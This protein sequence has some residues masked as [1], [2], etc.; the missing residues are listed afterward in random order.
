MLCVSCVCV[1]CAWLRACGCV[2]VC[3]VCVCGVW[4]CA[5]VWLRVRVSVC[6]D[7]YKDKCIEEAVNLK[8]LGIEIDSHLTWRNHIDQI[9]P[10][11]S[12]A[13]YMIR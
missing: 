5:C 3:G 4:V 6:S 8:F 7:C 1:V 9:I 13:C 11:P 2:R 10:K 12:T